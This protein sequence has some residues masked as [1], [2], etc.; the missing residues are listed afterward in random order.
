[1]TIPGNWIQI[2]FGLL[3]PTYCAQPGARCLYAGA[4]PGSEMVFGLRRLSGATFE[5]ATPDQFDSQGWELIKEQV[6]GVQLLAS[7]R[8]ML[9]GRPATQRVILQ[10]DV[11]AGYLARVI[12]L[13]KEADGAILQFDLTANA[14]SYRQHAAEV[15]TILSTLHFDNSREI[16]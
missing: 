2:D 11:E 16:F 13:I 10:P 3:S 1:M 8:R 6:K 15:E 7:G 5:H 14:A 9:D 12:V 4:R